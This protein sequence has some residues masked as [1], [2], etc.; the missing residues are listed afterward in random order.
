MRSPANFRER[1][2]INEN[3]L[4]LPGPLLSGSRPFGLVALSEGLLPPPL[5][6]RSHLLFQDA[7]LRVSPAQDRAD[8]QSKFPF[9]VSPP[10][11]APDV[12]SLRHRVSRNSPPTM[13][14]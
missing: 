8:R 7:C 14:G 11:L 1:S 9:A 10:A 12:S 4:S 5:Q 13:P 6:P 3:P 2:A